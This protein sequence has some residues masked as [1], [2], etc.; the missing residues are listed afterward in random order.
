MTESKPNMPQ[1]MG[2]FLSQSSVIPLL[3][4]EMQFFSVT[5]WYTIL[6][7]INKKGGV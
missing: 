7:P 5:L 6:G 4:K 3:W 1:A 2:D